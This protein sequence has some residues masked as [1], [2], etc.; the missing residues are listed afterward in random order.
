MRSSS[1]NI[2]YT[3]NKGMGIHVDDEKQV[4]AEITIRP[5]DQGLDWISAH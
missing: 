5:V 4:R 2:R 1:Y 3:K